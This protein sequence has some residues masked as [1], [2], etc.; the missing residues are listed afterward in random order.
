MREEGEEGREEDTD[1]RREKGECVRER[2]E[3]G[4]R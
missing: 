3:R 2:E 1:R 4:G